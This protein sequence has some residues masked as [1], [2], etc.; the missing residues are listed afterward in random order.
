[1]PTRFVHGA[2]DPLPVTASTDTADHIGAVVDVLPANGHFPW[3]EDPGCV[4]RSLD[5]LIVT[6]A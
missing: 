6:V 4:R 5:M 1:V 3:L 2:L